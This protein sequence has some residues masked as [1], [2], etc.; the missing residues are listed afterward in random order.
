MD[1]DLP[2]INGIDVNKEI[3]KKFPRAKIIALSFYSKF[4]IQDLDD[5]VYFDEFLK[6]PLI[7]EDFIYMLK[8]L[9]IDNNK[10]PI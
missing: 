5:E 9:I 7:L 3:R 6:K 2:K 1:I 10:A 4:E 8:K